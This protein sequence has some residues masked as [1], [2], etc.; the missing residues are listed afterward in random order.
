[1]RTSSLICILEVQCVLDSHATHIKEAKHIFICTIWNFIPRRR[2]EC[3]SE[4]SHYIHKKVVPGSKLW[5]SAA[6]AQRAHHG[7][8][9]A[10]NT[11][12]SWCDY[13]YY[14]M[15]MLLTSKRA[16]KLRRLWFAHSAGANSKRRGVVG[17]L[18]S[19]LIKWFLIT[20]DVD[21]ESQM[22]I[23]LGHYRCYNET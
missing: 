16:H 15:L 13:V 22:Y 12:R 4:L 7:G 2:V 1:M 20:W 6:H 5:S 17:S 19:G 10:Q 21:A 11:R 18:I 3:C 23:A 9:R 8:E 14:K